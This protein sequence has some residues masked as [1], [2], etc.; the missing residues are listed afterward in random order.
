MARARIKRAA[1]SCFLDV[2][3]TLILVGGGTVTGSN[4]LLRGFVPAF[5]AICCIAGITCV[6]GLFWEPPEVG[7]AGAC[8]KGRRQC[9][10]IRARDAIKVGH[11]KTLTHVGGVHM[12]RA[13]IKR[14]ARSC[15]LDVP[16]TLILVGRRQIPAIHARD[17]IKVGPVKTLAGR[18][19]GGERGARA[20]IKRAGV[21]VFQTT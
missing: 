9:P 17:T 13:R 10:A 4:A 3:Q 16:Q 20:L 12:A 2:P 1:R 19:V 6:A 11:A 14:A 8:T 5:T 7:F 15:S 18:Q 21:H